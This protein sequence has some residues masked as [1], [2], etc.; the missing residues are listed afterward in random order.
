M[1]RAAR[2]RARMS[3]A[4]LAAAAGIPRN[5][6]CAYEGGRRDLP[7]Q[8]IG[9]LYA[10]LA[11]AGQELRTVAERLREKAKAQWEDPVARGKK[12]EGQLRAWE[13]K[14]RAAGSRLVENPRGEIL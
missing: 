10:A 9:R 12:I 13:R 3:Q 4:A 11:V 7:A 1:L 6:L 5:A 14:R 2:L 8:A